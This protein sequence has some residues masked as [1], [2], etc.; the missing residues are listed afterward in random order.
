MENKL[1]LERINLSAWLTGLYVMKARIA[2]PALGKGKE[3]PSK[4][5]KVNMQEKEE[6]KMKKMTD[7]EREEY[8]MKQAIAQFEAFGKY[9]DAFNK[10]HFG[11]E[12]S[13]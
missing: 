12:A 1:E 11:G 2:S 7:E 13:D 10:Q 6:E 4:P 9:A 3:Y 8:E 5:I